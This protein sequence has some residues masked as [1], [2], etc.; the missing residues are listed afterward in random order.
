MRRSSRKR[1]WGPVRSMTSWSPSQKA[2]LVIIC[3]RPSTWTY[4]GP[5]TWKLSLMS[6]RMVWLVKVMLS[7]FCSNSQVGHGAPSAAR[8]CILETPASLRK[9]SRPHVAVQVHRPLKFGLQTLVF[10][11]NRALRLFEATLRRERTERLLSLLRG[12]SQPSDAVLCCW[13]GMPSCLRISFSGM[14]TPNQD[15]PFTTRSCFDDEGASC[16]SSAGGGEA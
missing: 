13:C 9:A 14:S 2:R 4:S 3:F 6:P 15:T 12:V 11:R 10:R 1:P 16:G 5:P 7:L 8:R